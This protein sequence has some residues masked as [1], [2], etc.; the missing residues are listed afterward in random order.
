MRHHLNVFESARNYN[1][2]SAGIDKDLTLRLG[3]IEPV[4]KRIDPLL[5]RPVRLTLDEFSNLVSFLREGLLDERAAK[6][7]LCP[8]IPG[9]LPSGMPPLRFEECPQSS[10]IQHEH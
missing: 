5:A 6:Q 4:L 10:H 2:R 3:P 1:P 9:T 7:N 8:L